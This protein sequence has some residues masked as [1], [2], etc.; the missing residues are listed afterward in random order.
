MVENDQQIVVK[1]SVKWL[2]KHLF[3]I[4]YDRIE[5]LIEKNLLH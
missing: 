3:S 5:I 2:E 1:N 4:F